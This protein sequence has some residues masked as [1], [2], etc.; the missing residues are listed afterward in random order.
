MKNINFKLNKGFLALMICI[1]FVAPNGIFVKHAHASVLTNIDITKVA[2]QTELPI[3]GGVVIYTYNVTNPN[4]V[5][6]SDVILS[7]NKCSTISGKSGDDN[8]NNLLDPGE[9]WTYDCS[10]LVTQTTTNIATVT[11][12]LN[13]A[14]LEF[15]QATVTVT[16]ATPG[17]PNLGFDPNTPNIGDGFVYITWA[18]LLVILISLST[19]FIL[20]RESWLYKKNENEKK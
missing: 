1:L 14:M 2:S 18:V 3:N 10:R 8:N 16:V 20:T 5:S 4:T 6:L 11:A 15:N 13:S 17:F 19:F 12:Y 9:V 7:D